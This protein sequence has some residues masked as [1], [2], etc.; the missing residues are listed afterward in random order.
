[1][2]TTTQRPDSAPRTDADRPAPRHRRSVP[3]GRI[4]AWAVMVIFL[5]IT[6][7]PF[8]WMLRT[9]LSS[10]NAL[11]TDSASLLPVGLN[12]GGFERVFG[13]VEDARVRAFGVRRQEVDRASFGDT[14]TGLGTR[15]ALHVIRA[16]SHFALLANIAEDLHRERR[17]STH[18][19]AGEEA[20][21]ET[22]DAARVGDRALLVPAG[23][24]PARGL[25]QLQGSQG[26]EEEDRRGGDEEQAA[27]AD[28]LA[29]EDAAQ[30]GEHAAGRD[31]RVDDGVEDAAAV[32]GGEGAVAWT[33]ALSW[34][35]RPRRW[36]GRADGAG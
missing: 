24:Q 33:P 21:I 18:I 5:L 19:A 27:P 4:A 25:R 9:A 3:W 36:P 14:L 32:L 20:L 35:W 30:R 15:D 8:Y 31:A 29:Q 12:T 11:A 2:T 16:F 28:G 34:P 10:N 6:L 13:L 1:M 23:Q 7:F 22:A 26:E 17:R